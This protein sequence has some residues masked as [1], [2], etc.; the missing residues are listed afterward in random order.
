MNRNELETAIRIA[1][2]ELQKLTYETL[3]TNQGFKM[4]THGTIISSIITALG[5]YEKELEAVIKEETAEKLR[6][7]A[8]KARAAKVSKED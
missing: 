1:R 5:W 3:R 4:R 6:E 2:S 8:A 7:N